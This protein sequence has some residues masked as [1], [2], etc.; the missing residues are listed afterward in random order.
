MSMRPTIAIVANYPPDHATFTGG[1]AT[2]TAALLEGLKPYQSDFDFH[3][4]STS[5]LIHA[6]VRQRHDGFSFHF[7]SIPDSRVLGPRIVLRMLKTDHEL[8]RI[9]PDLVHG[10][11]SVV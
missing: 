8:R 5:T 1:V 11:A 4:V 6:D 3:V 10:Q 2:A 9:A 7:L